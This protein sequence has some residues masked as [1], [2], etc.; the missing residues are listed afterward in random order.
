MFIHISGNSMT[1]S[2]PKSNNEGIMM[3]TMRNKRVTS[4]LNTASDENTKKSKLSVSDKRQIKMDI[5]LVSS[6]K[7]GKT[8][9]TNTLTK[10]ASSSGGI[11]NQ[12]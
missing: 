9:V 10:A 2:S 12:R 5:A 4:G 6:I 11:T 7:V 8:S 3:R 1:Q